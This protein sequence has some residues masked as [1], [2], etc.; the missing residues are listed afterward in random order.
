ML[1]Q[2][3]GY[4][5]TK[6]FVLINQELSLKLPLQLRHRFLR[7]C[8]VPMGQLCLTIQV[9]LAHSQPSQPFQLLPA[10]EGLM[11]REAWL[12]AVTAQGVAWY[13]AETFKQLSDTGTIEQCM[14]AK[15]AIAAG[16]EQVR[17]GGIDVSSQH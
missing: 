5:D 2:A 12:V 17:E 11:A 7:H 14:V 9:P 1:D 13:L 10:I 4:Q 6:Q 8:L 16:I 3:W 15:V